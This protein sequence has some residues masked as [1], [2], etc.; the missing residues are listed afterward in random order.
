[1]K[2]IIIKF[3]YQGVV[4]GISAPN[5]ALLNPKDKLVKS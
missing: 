5:K 4:V 1:M 2:P 3:F